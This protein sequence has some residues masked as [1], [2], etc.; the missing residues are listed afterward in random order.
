MLGARRAFVKEKSVAD[1]TGPPSENLQPVQQDDDD[2]QGRQR[3]AGPAQQPRQSLQGRL[4][5]LVRA[6]TNSR[7]GQT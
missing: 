7:S 6:A 4:P 1:R 3:A 5:L 2:Q